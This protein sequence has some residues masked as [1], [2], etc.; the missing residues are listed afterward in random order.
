MRPKTQY[1]YCAQNNTDLQRYIQY[2]QKDP[3]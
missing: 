1:Q 2:K 3:R